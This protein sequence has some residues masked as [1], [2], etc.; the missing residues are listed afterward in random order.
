MRTPPGL[1]LSQCPNSL[2]DLK[3]HMS[4]PTTL[5]FIS[6]SC[7]SS[8][9]YLTSSRLAMRKAVRVTLTRSQADELL[10]LSQGMCRRSQDLDDLRGQVASVFPLYDTFFQLA[11][12]RL[13]ILCRPWTP[14]LRADHFPGLQDEAD[15]TAVLRSF[16]KYRS[17]SRLPHKRSALPFVRHARQSKLD[18]LRLMRSRSLFDTMQADLSGSLRILAS[19]TPMK[20]WIASP[21]HCWGWRKSGLRRCSC[22]DLSHSA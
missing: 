22:P 5:T 7:S 14:S 12:H 9:G 21:L 19:I 15:H 11:T 8:V 4:A 6:R 1:F 2:S 18:R 17:Q 16:R 3:G 20:S 13:S 10:W